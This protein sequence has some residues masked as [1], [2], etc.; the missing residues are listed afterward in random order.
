MY[1]YT[2]MK[3]LSLKIKGWWSERLAGLELSV[4]KS[5]SAAYP[6]EDET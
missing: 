4:T 1:E 5:V 2:K 3:N 6:M